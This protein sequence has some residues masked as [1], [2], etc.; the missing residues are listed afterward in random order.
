[1][2]E[3][4]VFL[5][6][7]NLTFEA[8]SVKQSGSMIYFFPDEASTSSQT[9]VNDAVAVFRKEEIEGFVNTEA[10]N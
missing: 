2:A 3:Y 9:P 8:E 5:A 1:M 4:R 7:F 6:D 10:F